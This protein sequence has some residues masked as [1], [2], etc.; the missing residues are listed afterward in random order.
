MGTLGKATHF[1]VCHFKEDQS[2]PSGILVKAYISSMGPGSHR[3]EGGHCVG[4]SKM[5]VQRWS[6]CCQHFH[7]MGP[8]KYLPKWKYAGNE[9]RIYYFTSVKLRCIALKGN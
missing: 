1:S 3:P 6:Q 9:A 7:S 8:M 2:K 4:M 5:D